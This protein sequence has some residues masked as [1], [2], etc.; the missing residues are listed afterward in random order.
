MTSR[1][2]IGVLA[3][4]ERAGLK[5]F[6]ANMGLMLESISEKLMNSR[7]PTQEVAIPRTQSEVKMI[8]G[9]GGQGYRLLRGFSR[10]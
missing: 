5:P 6:N 9:T 7:V 10:R 1:T 2:D 3:E 8:R 4:S